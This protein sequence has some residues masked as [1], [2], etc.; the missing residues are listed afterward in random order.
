MKIGKYHIE[1]LL[2]CLKKNF[3]YKTLY[4]HLMKKRD[5]NNHILKI[6]LKNQILAVKLKQHEF[7]KSFNTIMN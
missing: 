5:I 6:H 3:K 4:Y 1:T 2:R 7:K